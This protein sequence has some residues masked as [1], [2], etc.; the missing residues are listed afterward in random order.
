[1]SVE[2]AATVSTVVLKFV[3]AIVLPNTVV[4]KAMSTCD[5][6]ALLSAAAADHLRRTTNATL[7]VVRSLAL[8]SQRFCAII[9]KVK[10]RRLAAEVAMS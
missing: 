4:M 8:V 2:G 3:R 7:Q 1:L 9:A 6:S 5:V 10:V